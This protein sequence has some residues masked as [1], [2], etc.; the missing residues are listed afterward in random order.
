M[1]K[2]KFQKVSLDTPTYGL[3]TDLAQQSGFTRSAYIRLLLQ[4]QAQKRN[5]GQGFE[6]S[7]EQYAM[8]AKAQATM[9]MAGAEIVIRRGVTMRFDDLTPL[10]QAATRVFQKFGWT[11][12]TEKW[13]REFLSAL[14]IHDNRSGH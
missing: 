8:D 7:V 4:A 12:D 2:L 3:L 1:E 13:K 10:Q 9:A 11:L 5:K 14:C 6:P